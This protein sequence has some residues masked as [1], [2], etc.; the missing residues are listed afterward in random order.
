MRRGCNTGE[1][2]LACELRQ[3]KPAFAL[4]MI[5]TNDVDGLASNDISINEYKARLNTIVDQAQQAGTIVVLST[6][7]PRLDHDGNL[8][9]EVTQVNQAIIEIAQ[10]KNIP[11]WNYWRALQDIGAT[12]NYGMDPDGIHPTVYRGDL[13]AIMEGVALN[14]GYNVRNYTGLQVLAKVKSIV[15]DNG[16]ADSAGSAPA[17][18]TVPSSPAIPTTPTPPATS[19]SPVAPTS[20]STPT[21]PAAPAVRTFVLNTSPASLSITQGATGRVTLGLQRQGGFTGSI[22]FGYDRLPANTRG[23]FN[24]SRTTGN[25]AQFTITAG[26]TVRPGS[27]TVNI[28]ATSGSITRTIAIPITIVSRTAPAPDFTLSRNPSSI[29]IQQ[30]RAESATISVTRLNGLN[31]AV[32]ITVTGLPTGVSV[33]SLSIG[34]GSTAGTLTLSTN[35]AAT[36]GT[37]TITIRATSGSLT[38]TTTLALTVTRAPTTSPTSP[39]TPTSPTAA[40][41]PSSPATPTLGSGL[42]YDIGNPTVRDIWV[43]PNGS[44]SNSGNSRTSPLATLGAAW[45]MIPSGDLTGTGYRIMMMSGTYPENTLPNYL[46]LKRGTAQFPIMIQAADGRGTVTLGGDLNVANVNHL[47]LIDIN[48]IPS[49]AGDTFHCEGCNHLLM[50]GMRLSGGN[51]SAHETVKINQSQYVYIEDSDISGANDNAID[52]VAVQYGHVVR[53]KIWNAEDWCMYAKGGSANLRIE[54]NE[55]FNCGTGGFTAG[56]GTGLEFMV[57]PWLHYEAYGIIFV[58]NVIHDTEGAGIGVNGGYNIVMAYNTMYKVG[59]RD[60]VIEAVFGGRECDGATRVC[61]SY[62]A[63]GGWGSTGSAG[64]P[65]PNKNVYIL[66]NIVLNPSGYK[67][68]RSHF[69]I[70]NPRTPSASSNIPS[71]ARADDNL[72]IKGNIIWNPG[73]DWG[74]GIESQSC[75]STNPTCNEAQ[76]LREN[77]IN[78]IQPQLINPDGGDF[79][80]TAGSNI[81]TMTSIALPSLNWSSLPARPTT[82][83]GP[84]TISVSV[85]RDGTSRSITSNVGAY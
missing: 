20:P 10:T 23:I 34:S 32:G 72:V 76:L 46:E 3:A 55:I 37:S 51:R 9:D 73:L 39:T 26:R 36:V 44:D 70:Y 75:T 71:P 54:G 56:Q 38:K 28:R 42:R 30:G 35:S 45:R 82:P 11:L 48:I 16:P 40:I 22:R 24:L 7:P 63:A 81:Q 78:T 21:A 65:I 18:P 17:A 83:T 84:T 33:N 74:L 19:V 60:H 59:S 25:T 69:A 79:R 66:N 58:N 53:N 62:L 57:N 1:T 4:I 61:E 41:T 49:P 64:E 85:N 27:Y 6:I 50:R 14:Y 12:N 5:G 2:Q 52:F 43:A 80:P 77:A 13:A 15:I 8:Q 67:R 47:Y 29:S 31:T 68:E